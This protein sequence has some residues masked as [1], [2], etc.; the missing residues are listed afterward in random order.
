VACQDI[1]AEFLA[2]P[3]EDFYMCTSA[4]DAANFDFL[5]RVRETCELYTPPTPTP[6]PEPTPAPTQSGSGDSGDD[7]G[8]EVPCGERI[9]TAVHFPRVSF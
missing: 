8:V 1:A 2:M 5:M 6:A 7:G 3:T 9:I 4:L